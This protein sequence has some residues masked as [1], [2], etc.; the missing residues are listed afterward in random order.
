MKYVLDFTL[1]AALRALNFAPGKF[2]RPFKSLPA[3]QSPYGRNDKAWLRSP[4]ATQWNPGMSLKT[5][6]TLRC[7]QAA[8]LESRALNKQVKPPDSLGFSPHPE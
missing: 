3:I 4:D 8:C 5:R 1:W 2:S 6:I 7:I